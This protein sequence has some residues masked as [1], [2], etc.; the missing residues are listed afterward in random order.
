[1]RKQNGE[2]SI[3][4]N[5]TFPVPLNTSSS[6]HN[7]IKLIQSIIAFIGL[8]PKK[9]LSYLDIKPEQEIDIELFGNL[10]IR[11][12]ALLIIILYFGGLINLI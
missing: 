5:L 6:R 3:D 12:I 11:Y 2:I 1:M 7:S 10:L 4:K 8:V 9:C